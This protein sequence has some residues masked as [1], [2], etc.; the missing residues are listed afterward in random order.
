[1]DGTLYAVNMPLFIRNYKL[2]FKK[3][4]WKIKTLCMLILN[5]ID[6]G[7]VCDCGVTRVLV[8]TYHRFCKI[9]FT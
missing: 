4:I 1:M 8:M 9:H 7:L 5:V 3:I 6:N 2:L